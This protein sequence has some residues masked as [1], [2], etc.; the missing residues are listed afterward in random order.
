M[1][2]PTFFAT[3]L[4][5]LALFSPAR[6]QPQENLMENNPPKLE[7]QEILEMAKQTRQETAYPEAFLLPDKSM[8]AAPE[9]K[10]YM[11][12]HTPF[13]NEFSFFLDYTGQGYG[14]DFVG[15]G[16]RCDFNFT[17]GNIISGHAM[18]PACLYPTREEL[19]RMWNAAGFSPQFFNAGQMGEAEMREA[20]KHALVTLGQPVILPVES[21]FFGS[22][23]VGY[24]KDGAVLVTWGY[25][26]LDMLGYKE[27][28]KKNNLRLGR[29][30]QVM[31]KFHNP[32]A[33]RLKRSSVLGFRLR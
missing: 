27:Y 6:E 25:P 32:A 26:P 14:F 12:N 17:L 33:S 4:L 9:M 2:H 16:W 21:R 13:P 10:H 23:V 24:K 15:D 19:T 3:S 7:N 20:V 18:R 1:K 28:K 5:S 8:K 31:W 11:D 30:S 22:I 29:G